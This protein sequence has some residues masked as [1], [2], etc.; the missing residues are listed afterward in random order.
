MAMNPTPNQYTPKINE[1]IA[2][3]VKKNT[4]P[5]DQLTNINRG[6]PN[7]A[8]SPTATPMVQQDPNLRKFINQFK[9]E[10]RMMG[11]N[12]PPPQKNIFNIG[13]DIPSMQEQQKMQQLLQSLPPGIDPRAV[14]ANPQGYLQQ[15]Q[16]QQRMQDATVY[17]G[18]IY[19]GPMGPQMSQQ[20]QDLIAKL[21]EGPRQQT[22]VPYM[23]TPGMPQ[24]Q[25]G[26]PYYMQ[27]PLQ[28]QQ[29]MQPQAPY[30]PTV[31]MPQT[32]PQQNMQN[33]MGKLQGMQSPMQT[34]GYPQPPMQQPV[35]GLG[36]LAAQP[37]FG[38]NMLGQ[39]NAFS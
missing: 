9:K 33:L 27:E 8:P 11:R 38:G 32:Q 14:Q 34:T 20:L 13:N 28:G 35:G 15:M 2:K 5:Y 37:S 6:K 19:K 25:P 16:E 10:E 4:S 30:M 23:P 24:Q 29:P 39:K 21:Q 7:I 18:P 31:G 12:S 22:Q 3:A 1:A 36:S 26:I 17:K